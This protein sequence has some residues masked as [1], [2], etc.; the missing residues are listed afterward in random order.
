MNYGDFTSSRGLKD[1]MPMWAISIARVFKLETLV[2][3]LEGRSLTQP[4]II[5]LSSWS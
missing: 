4:E 1:A 5:I 3:K 2:S